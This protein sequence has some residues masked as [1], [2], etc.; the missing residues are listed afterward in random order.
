M[1]KVSNPEPPRLH[2]ENVIIPIED[3]DKARDLI[4]ESEEENRPQPPE[5]RLND[6]FSKKEYYQK[7]KEHTTKLEKK[8][9]HR[10]RVLESN[11]RFYVQKKVKRFRFSFLRLFKG[12]YFWKN[13]D[14]GYPS[15]SWAMAFIKVCK[16]SAI[17][18]A[19]PDKIHYPETD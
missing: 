9:D 7:I 10:Y 2:G 8:I 3:Y 15:L 4:K 11:E 6:A 12:A 14:N 18:I 1:K 19:K 5:N 13:L 16:S 17:K